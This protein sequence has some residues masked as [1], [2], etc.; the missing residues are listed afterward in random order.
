[1]A[2]RGYKVAQYDASIEKGPYNHPNISFHKKF[3]GLLNNDNTVSL[4]T[5][6]KE[7][8]LD[9]SLPNILQCDIENAEWEILEGF[10]ISLLARYFS[11]I[12]F[13]FHGLNPEEAEGFAKRSAV[14][15]KINEHFSSIHM[16]FNNHGKIFYSKDRFFSVTIEASYL[17]KDLVPSYARNNFRK[18]G[19]LNKLDYPTDKAVPELP[20]IYE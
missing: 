11:Q 14:L 15:R 13:E 6:I 1:M 9:S 7:N 20:I 2:K 16:H 17:R 4:E 10:D 8:K 3:V 19:I 5:V 12:I 18:S